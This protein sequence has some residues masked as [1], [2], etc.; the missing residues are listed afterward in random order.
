M[1][2]ARPSAPLP[3]T[4]SP[5][6]IRSSRWK[7][8]AALLVDCARFSGVAVPLAGGSASGADCAGGGGAS[9]GTGSSGKVRV[10]CAAGALRGAGEMSLSIALLGSIARTCAGAA[11]PAIS[12]AVSPRAS[13]TLRIFNLP[14]GNG[15]IP[16]AE[17][18]HHAAF[19][20]MNR[21]TTRVDFAPR[22]IRN[23]SVDRRDSRRY[24][25]PSRRSRRRG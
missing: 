15:I 9:A 20:A 8:S 12:V 3:N 7:V 11:V 13:I 19:T 25:P 22:R 1:I 23:A 21:T 24:S 16:A 4:P 14:P 17:R 18:N 5:A 10:C 6:L 2:E